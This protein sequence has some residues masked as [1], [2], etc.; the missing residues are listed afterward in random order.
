MTSN[1]HN[2][3]T[4]Q[5]LDEERTREPDEVLDWLCWVFATRGERFYPPDETADGCMEANYPDQSEWPHEKYGVE[6]G[7]HSRAYTDAVEFFY[8]L[9][10]HGYD[11]VGRTR[12]SVRRSREEGLD[13]LPMPGFEWL[14]ASG[15]WDRW[16]DE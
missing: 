4:T 1:E 3:R 2:T 10:R 14:Y 13:D 8:D 7:Q 11:P 6:K 9:K 12:R 16:Q 15:R 5:E